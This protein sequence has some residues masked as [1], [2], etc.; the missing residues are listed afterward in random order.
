MSTDT[1][2]AIITIAN[3]REYFD[4]KELKSFLR[5]LDE[6]EVDHY[7]FTGPLMDWVRSRMFA[8]GDKTMNVMLDVRNKVSPP[9]YV[10]PVEPEAAEPVEEPKEGT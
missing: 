1:L 2:D 10:K 7:E 4:E 8:S 6:A 9:A 3:H 5:Q